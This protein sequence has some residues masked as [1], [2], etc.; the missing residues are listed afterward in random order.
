[1]LDP[2]AGTGATRVAAQQLGRHAVGIA[3]EERYFEAAAR[4]LELALREGPGRA[5]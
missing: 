2:F 5:A 3:L 1:M 4:R